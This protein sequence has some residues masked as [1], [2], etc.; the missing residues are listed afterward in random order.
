MVT[1][2]LDKSTLQ[3]SVDKSL[4]SVE[5]IHKC[6]YWYA[7]KYEIDIHTQDAICLINISNIAKEENT[8]E[9]I[10]K[11]KRDLVDFK[12]REIIS[13]ETKSIRELLIAKAFAHDDSF[14]EDPPG[15]VNDPLGFDPTKI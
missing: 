12:T 10:G 6:F 7:N 15:V 14:D 8:Q 9:L 4:Y 2:F 3:V 13:K 5:V 1:C 11:I